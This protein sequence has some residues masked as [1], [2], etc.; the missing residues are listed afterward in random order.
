M[1]IRSPAVAGQFYP[2][3]SYELERM[4][5]DC[6]RVKAEEMD[7]VGAVC[8]H[9]GYQF[10]GKTAGY[11]YKTIKKNFDTVVILGPNHMGIGEGVTTSLG[12]WKTPLGSVKIDDEFAQK[13]ADD[14]IISVD[15]RA[16][17]R[18]HSIEVQL[19]FL[20]HRFKDFNF[21]PISINPIY[22]QKESCKPIGEK[23]AEVSKKLKRKIIVIASS[24]FTHYGKV[25][26]YTP[27]RGPTSQILKR[28]KETDMEV[29]RYIEK[30]MPERIL[31]I[32]NDKRLSV[33]GY[34][35]ISAML[36]TAK[37]LGAKK[38]R[39]LNYSSSFESSRDINAVVA[40]AG[41]VIF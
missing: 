25:Y 18:E 15:P 5:E 27:Y 36:W 26:N 24:D 2:F 16:H 29:I 32:C 20:Q 6:Y 4:L 19:P 1:N 23:I 40:Y 14:S 35:G 31:E 34:G 13:L 41:I 28:I 10:S 12:I 9:A 37:K 3:G 22:Y 39:L 33:C 21:V 7:V 30:M 38:G 11:V 17:L 8:P